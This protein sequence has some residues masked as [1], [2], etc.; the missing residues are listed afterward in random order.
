[1]R[2]LKVNSDSCEKLPLPILFVTPLL[3]LAYLALLKQLHTLRLYRKARRLYSSSIPTFISFPSPLPSSPSTPPDTIPDPHKYSYLPKMAPQMP[4]E[5]LKLRE[6]ISQDPSQG[7]AAEGAWD[8]A[9]RSGTTP[10]D[11]KMKDVQPSLRELIEE[12]WEKTGVEWESLKSGKA[13]V[14]GCGRVCPSP[15]IVKDTLID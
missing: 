6:L 15:Y 2:D 8:G 10:W 13:L 12:K 1:M 5:I 11:S 14:A 7:A 9:W 4:A 3:A